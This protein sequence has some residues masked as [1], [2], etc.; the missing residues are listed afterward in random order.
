MKL[1]DI[2]TPG[3]DA[4]QWK[5]KGYE[6][7]AFDIEAVKKNTSEAPTWVHFIAGKYSS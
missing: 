2:L 4:S 6:L 3:F 5:E 1:N 7:P